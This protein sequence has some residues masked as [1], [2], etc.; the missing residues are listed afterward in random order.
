[1]NFVIESALV[2]DQIGVAVSS[3]SRLP[4][5]LADLSVPEKLL[6][7]PPTLTD[8]ALLLLK[9]SFRCLVAV[10][11]GPFIDCQTVFIV[12]PIYPMGSTLFPYNPPIRAEQNARRS[13][14]KEDDQVRHESL[15]HE[16]PAHHS[17]AHQRPPPGFG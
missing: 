5:A 8:I 13:Q 10:R 7:N 11:K 16:A 4:L 2:G 12:S 17:H 3:K 6:R 15:R 14:S 1:R 9:T